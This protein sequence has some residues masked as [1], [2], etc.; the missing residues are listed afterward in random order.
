MTDHK[1]LK[2]DPPKRAIPMSSRNVAVYRDGIKLLGR[3][4]LPAFD[5]E[6][7]KAPAV[8]LLHGF[9]GHEKFDDLAQGLRR[10]GFVVFRT[11]FA[12]CWGSGGLYRFSTLTED[13]KAEL[14][15]FKANAEELHV[16]TDR[17]YLIGHSMGGLTALRALADG[18]KVRG[19]CLLAPCNLAQR[20]N[21]EE[22]HFDEVFEK[23]LDFINTPD[24]SIDDLKADLEGK[25]EDW[26]FGKLAEKIDP[27]L[28]LLFV[29]G[30]QDITCPAETHM[31]RAV[32]ALEK[33]G[34]NVSAIVLNSDHS[35]QDERISLIEVVTYA[36]IGWQMSGKII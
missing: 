7:Q 25:L 16:D 12:G 4:L 23:A 33:R 20:L 3:I 28:P 10:C 35:F 18:L 22:E 8:L 30:S 14:D 6:E 15:Y 11:G 34:A 21:G 29:G 2:A 19:A 26:E 1:Y 13:L 32:R 5:E 36:L 27:M 9:P 24:N 17:I 31:N